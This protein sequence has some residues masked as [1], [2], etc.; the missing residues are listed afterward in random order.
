MNWSE[1]AEKGEWAE[2]DWELLP[3]DD[4]LRLL[5]ML[6]LAIPQY[7]RRDGYEGGF[8]HD[9]PEEAKLRSEQDVRNRGLSGL[10]ANRTV[11]NAT[12][13]AVMLANLEAVFGEETDWVKQVA[14]YAGEVLS[15]AWTVAPEAGEG[16]HIDLTGSTSYRH[17][18]HDEEGT[19]PAPE[20]T[21]EAH[22]RRALEHLADYE[23]LTALARRETKDDKDAEW[24]IEMIKDAAAL[25]YWA[26]R[27]I[28]AASGKGIEYEALSLKPKAEKYDRIR[29]GSKKPRLK[30]HEEME[31]KFSDAM[32]EMRRLKSNRQSVSRA[33]EL[34]SKQYVDSET[35]KLE[36]GFSIANLRKR[37]REQKAD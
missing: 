17:L 34:V 32:T 16:R 21:V 19:E 37:Y 35:G 13:A 22:A 10:E 36:D 7:D 25:G 18:S 23:W 20:L 15:D 8:R 29:E 24:L 9:T 6:R 26:G 11:R 27:R 5:E 1:A 4:Q 33:A 31:A 14:H 30:I 2:I 28:Q 12:E 3:D